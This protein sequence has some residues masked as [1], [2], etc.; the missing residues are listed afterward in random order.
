MCRRASGGHKGEVLVRGLLP[1]PRGPAEGTLLV[2]ARQHVPAK[3][4]RIR[5]LHSTP[6]Q[7]PTCD[8]EV[9]GGRYAPP[10]RMPKNPESSEEGPDVDINNR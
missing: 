8:A 9:A 2:H 10:A 4:R 1:P 6:A 5:I 7:V 3:V